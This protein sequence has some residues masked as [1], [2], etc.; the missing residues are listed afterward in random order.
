[1]PLSRSL[2]RATQSVENLYFDAM[3]AGDIFWQTANGAPPP[4]GQG[5]KFVKLSA[6]EDGVGGVNEGLLD[7]EDT[8]GTGVEVV[9]TAEVIDEDSELF[10]QTINLVNSERRYL[11]ASETAGD[12]EQD[13]MQKITGIADQIGLTRSVNTSNHQGAFFNAG[14]GLESC[15][16]SSNAG[17]R[18]GFDSANSPNARTS[19]TTDGETHVKGITVTGWMKL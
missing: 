3:K 16:S 7:F 19:A 11:R 9:I 13:Q 14:L 5:F 17:Y 6:G 1:M 12:L 2:K 4:T 18:I 15:D 10:G 8:Q